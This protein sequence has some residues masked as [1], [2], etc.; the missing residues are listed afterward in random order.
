[1]QLIPEFSAILSVNLCFFLRI[2]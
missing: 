2:R 1:M